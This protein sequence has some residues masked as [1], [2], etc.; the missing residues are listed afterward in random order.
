MI[1]PLPSLD[2]RSEFSSSALESINLCFC[3]SRG[4]DGRFVKVSLKCQLTSTMHSPVVWQY[5]ASLHRSFRQSLHGSISSASRVG[6]VC[7]AFIFV[8]D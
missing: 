5:L 8:L 7:C 1:E 3:F 6:H 2:Q 4:R